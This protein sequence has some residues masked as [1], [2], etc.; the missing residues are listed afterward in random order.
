MYIAKFEHIATGYPHGV[1]VPLHMFLLAKIGFV[2]LVLD[3]VEKTFEVTLEDFFF[4][5]VDYVK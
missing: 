3:W 2:D 5:G 1:Q 4:E